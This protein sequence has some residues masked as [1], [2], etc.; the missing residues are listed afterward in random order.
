MQKTNII[1]QD[2]RSRPLTYAVQVAT[3]VI[4]IFNLY[5]ANKLQ[6]IA[7]SAEVNAGHIQELKEDIVGKTLFTAEID[8]LKA[9]LDRIEKKLDLVLQQ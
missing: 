5:L 9:R 3:I 6:P 2:V 8:N 4:L 1:M 7:E